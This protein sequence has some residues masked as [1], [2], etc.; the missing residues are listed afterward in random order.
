MTAISATLTHKKVTI[1]D[2]FAVILCLTNTNS[3]H[4]EFSYVLV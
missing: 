2:G 3:N 4:Q 1:F